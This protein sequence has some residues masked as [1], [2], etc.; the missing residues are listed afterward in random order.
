MTDRTIKN[1]TPP[2]PMS[3]ETYNYDILLQKQKKLTGE[4]GTIS[5]A[6]AGSI[7]SYKEPT[8][9]DEIETD[10]ALQN[11]QE[12]DKKHLIN[13]EGKP[14]YLTKYQNKLIYALSVFMSQNREDEE[15]KTYVEKLNSGKAPKSNITLPISITEIT[16]MVELDGKARARQKEKVLEELRNLSEIKQVQDYMVKGTKDGKVRFIAPFI[17]IQ[18][19]LEDLSPDKELN[20]DFV[21]VSFG[22]IFFYELYN[23][24]AIIKPS[25]FRIWGKAGSG[26]D[27]ELFNI[28]L[29]DL[30]SKYSGHRIAALRAVASLK[31]GRY[32]TDASYYAAKTKVQKAA[33]TYSEYSYNLRRR[34]TTDYESQRVYKALFKK[35][36]QNAIG[37]LIQIGL[38]TE[39]RLTMTDKGERIDFVFN[40]DYDKG[41]EGGTTLISQGEG[42]DVFPRIDLPEEDEPEKGE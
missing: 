22:S 33:L 5:V 26:T 13:R 1:A 8:L 20:A 15:I 4:T 6:L 40:L 2:L 9:F 3:A 27:T 28:L 41:D 12:I 14:V 36:L 17:Q 35:H 7:S 37:A 10:T 31:R 16:K 11:L 29:S 32:K 21:R 25:L 34:V 38:I 39:A 42:L 24:Y 19:Q 18:E 30:L 23:R